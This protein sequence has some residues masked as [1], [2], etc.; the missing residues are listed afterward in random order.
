M[1]YIMKLSKKL[2]AMWMVA[3]KI[4]VDDILNTAVHNHLKHGMSESRTISKAIEELEELI[5]DCSATIDELK[6][7]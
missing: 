5:S 2:Q 1:V 3:D 6:E 4:S 7:F